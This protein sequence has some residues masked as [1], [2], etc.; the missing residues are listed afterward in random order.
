MAVGDRAPRGCS[1]SQRVKC[2]WFGKR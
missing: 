1:K 2:A